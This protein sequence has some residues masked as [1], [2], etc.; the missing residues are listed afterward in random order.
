LRESTGEHT[1]SKTATQLLKPL[2][3]LQQLHLLHLQRHVKATPHTDDDA[4]SMMSTRPT[5]N[6][7]PYLCKNQEESTHQQK[8]NAAAATAAPAAC[9][10]YTHLSLNQEDNTH[11]QKTT[12]QQLQ[13]LHLLHL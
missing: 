12:L 1:S 6:T 7:T 3:L 2:Q 5:L 9:Q 13:L 4:F 8:N 11:Q 10:C